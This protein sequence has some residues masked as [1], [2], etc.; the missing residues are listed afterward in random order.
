MPYRTTTNRLYTREIKVD[1]PRTDGGSGYVTSTLK[2]QLRMLEQ[3]EQKKCKDDD[4]LVQAALV[5]GID[6]EDA[7]E[8]PIP[9]DKTR[10]VLLLDPV[11]VTAIAREIVE[12]SRLKNFQGR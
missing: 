5:K 8:N 9:D 3:P 7:D 1:Q 2:V 10:E 11:A 12:V 6:I 4:A